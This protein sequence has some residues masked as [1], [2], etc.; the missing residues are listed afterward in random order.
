MPEVTGFGICAVKIAE[1]SIWWILLCLVL[2]YG[3]FRIPNGTSKSRGMIKHLVK[4]RTLET[5]RCC[6]WM[7]NYPDEDKFV[8]AESLL[9]IP[10]STSHVSFQ[11]GAMQNSRP[12]SS[13]KML[14]T[15][16]H[17]THSANKLPTCSSS[18]SDKLALLLYNQQLNSKL[19]NVGNAM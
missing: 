13:L 9:L 18:V 5:S 15:R 19:I 12:H 6:A 8:K 16:S 2:K 11:S 17:Q 3:A 7:W 10:N 1:C 4:D 14:R